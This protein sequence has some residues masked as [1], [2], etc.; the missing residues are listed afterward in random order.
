[1]KKE[2]NFYSENCKISGEL[3]I[4]DTYQEGTQLPAIILCHGFAG[5]KELLLPAYA[6]YFSQNGFIA[7]TFDY[8]GFGDSEGDRGLLI[9]AEQIIDI[10]NAITFI[11][12]LLEIDLQKIAL[13]GTSFG[14]ANAISTAAVD[15]RVKCIV[16]QI[17]FGNGER[18]ITGS[19]SAEEKNKL[20]ATLKKDWQRKVTKNKALYLNADQILTDEE[21]KTFYQDASEKFPKL[22]VKLPLSTIRHNLE[23]KPENALAAVFV[24]L[25]IIGAEND[26]VCP[27]SESHFLFEK[28]G[29]PKE[30]YIIKNAKHYDLYE[31]ENFKLSSQK[32]LN[33][34]QKHLK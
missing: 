26:T 2:I 27:V 9:P 13:W 7:L 34:F 16:A 23:Y 1:M 19:L 29:E 24:P 12:S 20:E 18:M 28:A 14:G 10:R 6:E 32:A 17:T 3:F 21:S 4:P 22:K 25:L 11:E 15:N 8:R 31:G 30:L 5:I 33:W